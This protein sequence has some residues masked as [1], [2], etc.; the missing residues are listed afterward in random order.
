MADQVCGIYSDNDLLEFGGG[1]PPSYSPRGTGSQLFR[2]GT[3]FT[4]FYICVLN[5]S[6]PKQLKP[7]EVQSITEGNQSKN[8][9]QKP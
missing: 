1:G 8:L 9:K 6:D 5:H 4:F 7:Y 2:K 3:W